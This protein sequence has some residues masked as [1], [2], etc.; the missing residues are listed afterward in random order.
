M[1]YV[2]RLTF[3][4]HNPHKF[5]HVRD[6]D[7]SQEDPFRSLLLENPALP[8]CR[9]RTKKSAC[10]YQSWRDR[11]VQLDNETLNQKLRGELSDKEGIIMIE[12]IGDE[13][14]SILTGAF[15]DL[16]LRSLHQ[17]VARMD[18]SQASLAKG[19]NG[20]DVL[21]HLSPPYADSGPSHGSHFDGHFIPLE[22]SN[23][24]DVSKVASNPAIS[25]TRYYV[26]GGSDYRIETF[27]KHNAIW[28]RSG[29]R[30][31]C[32]LLRTNLCRLSSARF[33]RKGWLTML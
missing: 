3:D 10:W 20:N 25:F 11:A 22:S 14:V 13:I 9:D 27:V 2:N 5:Y 6:E 33:T 23:R 30:I 26:L 16:D 15:P 8:R 1:S 24:P 28:Y 32:C 29:S 19:L 4:Y 18:L 17:H 21:E 12:E 7:L 31:S